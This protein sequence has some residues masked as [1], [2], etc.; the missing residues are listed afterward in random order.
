M[1]QEN[2]KR[3]L[4]ALEKADY[5]GV[6]GL[7]CEGAKVFSPLYGQQS[8]ASFYRDL[9]QDT[10]QSRIELLD[11][12]QGQTARNWGVNFLYHWTLA[13]GAQTTFDCVDLFEFDEMGKI[14]SLRIIYDT[15]HTRPALDSQ[16]QNQI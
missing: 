12:Y 8:P 14:I 13:E 9:F 5:Q 7:F 6:I 2:I 15:Q 4:G 11:I 1:I 16:R 3:Y 10:H